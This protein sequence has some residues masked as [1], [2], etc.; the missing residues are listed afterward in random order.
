LIALWAFIA[1]NTLVDPTERSLC[2][3][4]EA[5][6][7]N[8]IWDPIASVTCVACHTADG[9]AAE[10]RLVMIDSDNALA[11]NLS[12]WLE[13]AELEVQG[14]PLLLAKPSGEHPEAHTGGIQLQPGSEA[15]LAVQ[16]FVGRATG[17]D[18]EGP[19]EAHCVPG[20]PGRRQLRRLTPAELS[21][22]ITDLLGLHRNYGDN[23]TSDPTVDGWNNDGQALVLNSLQAEQLQAL[24]EQVAGEVDLAELMTC[25]PSGDGADCAAVFVAQF[26]LRAF[27]RPLENFESNAYQ[28]LWQQVA[29]DQGFEAGIR[30]VIEAL[31]QSPHFLYRSELGS[32]EESGLYALS[33]W[34]LATALSYLVLGSLPDDPLFAAAAAGEL[35]D[36]AGLLVQLERLLQTVRGDEGFRRFAVGWLQVEPLATVSRDGG[37]YPE[38]TRT[39]RDGLDEEFRRLVGAVFLSGGDLADLLQTQETWVDATVAEFYGI[40]APTAPGLG[41]FGPVSIADPGLLGRG[42]VVATHA[43]PT[44]S[45]PVHRGE[46][47][48]ERLLCQKLPEPP[49]NLETA[50]PLEQEG[51]TTRERY[52][53]HSEQSECA[54]C[55]E[56]MDPI[57]FGLEHYDGVGRWRD[58][59]GGDDIDARGEITR[60]I[61]SDGVFEGATALAEQLANSAEVAGCFTE[62][63]TRWAF[64]SDELAMQCAQRDLNELQAAQGGGLA[65]IVIAATQLAHF[66]GRLGE[67]GELDGPAASGVAGEQGWTDPEGW[68][69]SSSNPGQVAPDHDLIVNWDVTTTWSDGWCADVVVENPSSETVIWELV[70]ELGGPLDSWWSSRPVPEGARVRFSGEWWNTE[71]EAGEATDF[72]FCVGR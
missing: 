51:Q 14:E 46:L 63:W 65:G 40:P 37:T 52:A 6:F 45:S 41:G 69:G 15:Y 25:V 4:S 48:R 64:A 17:R 32:L 43:L 38:F 20:E 68:L 28:D 27:R 33:D 72:G 70:A 1:C 35:R 19:A 50:A 29:Q 24:A 11:E 21:A 5:E 66:V 61:E 49:A 62:Q 30:F 26:G 39:V 9:I 47:V 23:L 71:L 3:P 44:A 55:H 53:A 56:L 2:L 34:E 54:V 13:F 36:P 60:S 10:T 31:L 16:T 12:R 67:P 57:G 42:A 7:R 8:Q 22:T 59:D 18:C 58:S